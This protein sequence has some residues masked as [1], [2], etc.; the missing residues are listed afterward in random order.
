[1]QI[2]IDEQVAVVV[3]QSRQSRRVDQARHQPE[4]NERRCAERRGKC[5]VLSADE[6]PRERGDE[7]C[8]H[9][10]WQ[11]RPHEEGAAVRAEPDFGH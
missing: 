5:P 3:G 7:R 10:R 2:E 1:M 11:N 9:G 4:S 8:Q 6:T